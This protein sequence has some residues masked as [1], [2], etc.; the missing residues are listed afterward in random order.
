MRN[1]IVG[2]FKLFLILTPLFS[3]EIKVL[4]KIVLETSPFE[5]RMAVQ[6]FDNPVLLLYFT[7]KG[8]ILLWRGSYLEIFSMIGTRLG[9]V[10]REGQGPGEFQMGIGKVVES[11]G[12]FYMLDYPHTISVFDANFKFKKRFFLNK[13]PFPVK[14]FDVCGEK[15]FAVQSIFQ[16]EN[17]PGDFVFEYDLKWKLPRSFLEKSFAYRYYPDEELLFGLLTCAKNNTLLLVLKTV[18]K[19][20][21]F[22]MNGKTLS[23]KDFAKDIFKKIAFDKTDYEK[24]RK[25]KQ[26]VYYCIDILNTGDL[27]DNL[28]WYRGR[29]L[30]V[31][32]RV[33][34]GGEDYSQSVF[35]LSEDLKKEFGPVTMDGYKFAENSD[36]YLFFSRYLEDY[37]PKGKTRIEVLRCNLN[38]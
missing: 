21:Q 4:D 12:L 22:D 29:P 36:N 7:K 9:R 19:L 15:I 8:E 34:K 32:G 18:N 24:S 20:F 25:K 33:V 3:S 1:W 13:V 6:P 27:I 5:G 10:G 37:N 28:S 14:D 26:R 31:V 30:L 11:E 38:F 17:I 35:L 2:L 23:E 16:K